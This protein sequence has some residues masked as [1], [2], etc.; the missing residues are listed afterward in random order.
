MKN[1]TKS[2]I[3]LP[4]EELRRVKRLKVRLKLGSN[5]DVVRAGLRMLEESS[6]REAL[7]EAFRRAS[8]ATRAGALEEL[9]ELDHLVGEGLE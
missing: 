9:A 1:N 3:T 5:V 2:S 6:D 7:R 8:Q 4:A